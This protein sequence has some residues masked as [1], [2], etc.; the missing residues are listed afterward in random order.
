MGIG[1]EADVENQI[2]LA[3]EAEAVREG[4]DR[5]RQAGPAVEGEMGA[6]QALQIADG[7]VGAVD[8]QVRPRAQGI[9][10]QM[11]LAD[12]VG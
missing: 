5:D 8:D 2:G 1:Q 9:Q 4:H 7:E 10:Q 6:D 3:R 11:L 12:P